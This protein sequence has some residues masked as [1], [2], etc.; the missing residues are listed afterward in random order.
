VEDEDLADAARRADGRLRRCLFESSCEGLGVNWREVLEASSI[1]IAVINREDDPVLDLAYFDS[2][3]D[4]L[5]RS[6]DSMPG[7]WP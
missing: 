3:S 5:G 2:L 4:V 7:R 6:C 1:P